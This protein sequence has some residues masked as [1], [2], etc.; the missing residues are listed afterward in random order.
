MIVVLLIGRRRSSS[1]IATEGMLFYVWHIHDLLLPARRSERP[2][3]F[4][5]RRSKLVDGNDGV[6]ATMPIRGRA[7][8]R[9]R[10]HSAVWRVRRQ[11]ASGKCATPNQAVRASRPMPVL[12]SVSAIESAARST[13]AL[14][15]TSSIAV[16]WIAP[17]SSA[18]RTSSDLLCRMARAMI[19]GRSA[20]QSSFS[21]GLG[22]G[23]AAGAKVGFL[24]RQAG[25]FLHSTI[26][27]RGVKKTKAVHCLFDKITRAVFLPLQS[28]CRQSASPR[29]RSCMS[30]NGLFRRSAPR[31]TAQ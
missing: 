2:P 18:I 28:E 29:L 10:D 19:T 5:G 3:A 8:E 26:D 23:S 4:C 12:A 11:T 22:A 1:A 9:R 31:R 14:G 21:I 17:A 16:I 20:G 27:S 15:L 7:L 24:L 25:K 6:H 30:G 13:G